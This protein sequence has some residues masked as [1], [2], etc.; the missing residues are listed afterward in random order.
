MGEA[1]LIAS[2]AKLTRQQ[3]AA[4]PTPLGTATHRPV[5]H[6][7]VIEVDNPRVFAALSPRN[8]GGAGQSGALPGG[9]RPE[10]RGGLQRGPRH[11][12]PLR[13]GPVWGTR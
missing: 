11:P 8:S 13:R 3:L 5:P 7:E 9:V 6:A 1:T 4:V 12:R 2:T 10:G